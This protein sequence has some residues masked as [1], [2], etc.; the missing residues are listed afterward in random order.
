MYDTVKEK[1]YED[2]L[3]LYD[4]DAD[5]MT[6][7]LKSEIVGIGEVFNDNHRSQVRIYLRHGGH[8]T[9]EY[10]GTITDTLAALFVQ[11]GWK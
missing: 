10:Y 9:H 2:V 7:I 3:V 8:I 1:L 4:D 6:F 11:M 5:P